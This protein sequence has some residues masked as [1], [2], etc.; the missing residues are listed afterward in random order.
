MIPAITTAIPAWAKIMP[1][2]ARGRCSARRNTL[3]NGSA[4]RRTRSASSVS[5]PA[6]SQAA[7][8][9]P[10]AAPT[11]RAPVAA[12]VASAAAAVATN[13]NLSRASAARRSPRFHG[14]HRPDRH[15][16]QE[17]DHDRHKGHRVEG[18]ADRYLLVRDDIEEQRIE[19][20]DEAPSRPRSSASRLF[21]SSPPSREIGAKRPPP[22]SWG[23]RQAKSSSA[24]PV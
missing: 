6:N 23:A 14:K 21:R 3:A 11:E 22:A 12:R 19:R 16:D 10:Q 17:R 7:S 1:Q 4:K 9:K 18:R 13:A 8:A 24:P 2:A 5:V 15:R 20:A